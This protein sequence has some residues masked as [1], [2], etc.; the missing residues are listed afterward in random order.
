[1][2]KETY[3]NQV[4]L[5]LRILPYFMREP[6]FALK[7]GTAINLFYQDMPRLSVYIDLTYL[8]IE[9]REESFANINA[10]FEA[11]VAPLYLSPCGRDRRA[12][13]GEGFFF[14]IT[15]DIFLLLN[16]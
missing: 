7:G 10:A 16:I 1:V 11:I 14:Y 15:L 8:P 6:K 13:A 2:I 3:H 9:T 4:Q 5:L 12:A